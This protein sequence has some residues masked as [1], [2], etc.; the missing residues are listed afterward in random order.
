MIW[1]IFA[2]QPGTR[3]DSEDY[4]RE[5]FSA[6]VIAVGWSRLGNLNRIASRE[7]LT[8]MV[9][10]LYEKGARAS[11]QDAGSLWRFRDSVK[12]GHLVICPDR[13]SGRYY[14]GKVLPGR[15]SHNKSLLGGRCAFPH[16]RKVK[17]LHVLSPG[18]IASI[19]PGG[20]RGGNQT[21][22][23][24][25]SGEDRLQK[26]IGQVRRPFVARPRLPSR[27][28]TEWGDL[29]EKRAMIW[30]KD[31]GYKPQNDAHRNLGWDITCGEDKFEVKGR[32]SSR[33]AVRLSQ[34][35]W[36]AARRFK[37]RYTVLIFTAPTFDKLKKASPV[38]IPDPTRTQS[39]A[40]KVTCEYVLAE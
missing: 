6:G 4:A 7:E 3:E 16:R 9:A 36:K 20:L 14:V 26:R 24:I 27:P 37:G 29:A 13:D 18:E 32:K 28:D 17:W 40:R 12:P 38:Q 21:V 22:T 10:K 15:V 25:R 35:E 19:W 39:W 2:R 34:N 5:C 1:K 31:K 30:L 11:G 33:V 23:E 8:R